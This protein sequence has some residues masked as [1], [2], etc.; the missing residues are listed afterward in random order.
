L[1]QLF[2]Y[3]LPQI[4]SAKTIPQIQAVTAPEP[5][6][7][8]PLFDLPSNRD[9]FKLPSWTEEESEIVEATIT[10][11]KPH[12]STICWLDK[13]PLAIINGEILAKGNKDSKFQFRVDTITR[14][15]VGIRFMGNG[16][17]EWLTLSTEENDL[18]TLK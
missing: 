1:Y 3:K 13:S 10:L 5:P 15:K 2:Q 7:N 17:Y 12:L 6:S 4:T 8:Q 14:D 11:P 18:S 16:E 9:I